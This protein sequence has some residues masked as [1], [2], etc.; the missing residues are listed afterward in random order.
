MSK[1]AICKAGT[2]FGKWTATGLT[3]VINRNKYAECVCQCGFKKYV[4]ITCLK[5]GSSKGCKKC[6]HVSHGCT[7]LPWYSNCLHMIN[8][9]YNTNN[10]RFIDYG[11]RGI[12]VCEEWRYNPIEFGKWAVNNGYN[13]GLQIDRIDVNGNYNEDN[14]RWVTCVENMQNR[15]NTI[16]VS[17]KGSIMTLADACRAFS[18]NYSTVIKNARRKHISESKS[19][20]FY[21]K[22][23]SKCD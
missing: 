14:C 5:N 6:G 7:R 19:F 9:C 8:R 20:S 21:I 17:V 3:K 2:K 1:G 13:H 18:V 10:S 16:Y 4:R 23:K 12:S 15:R 11:G 22:D